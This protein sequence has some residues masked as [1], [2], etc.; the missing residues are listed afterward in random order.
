M[1]K[2]DSVSIINYRDSLSKET[3]WY[4]SGLSGFIKKWAALGWPGVE[5]DAPIV[6]DEMRVEGNRK[7]TAVRTMDPVEGPLTDIE[8]QA[9]IDALKNARLTGEIAVED[10]ALAW[11]AILLS[12]RPIQLASL[13]ICDLKYSTSHDGIPTYVLRVP[14]AKQRGKLARDE[15]FDRALLPEI[16]KLISHHI[17]EVEKRLKGF[18]PDVSSAPLFPAVRDIENWLDGFE[19]HTTADN[20]GGRITFILEGLAVHSERTGEPLNIFPTRLRRTLG[21]HAAIEGHGELLIAALLDHS[22]TQNAG[23]YVEARPEI[24]ERIDKAIAMRMAPL[25]Q[26]F[27]GVLVDGAFG[28]DEEDYLISDPRYGDGEQ[29]V[30]GCGS[31]SFCSLAAPIACYTC[32]HFRP[33]LDGP[34]EEILDGLLGERDRLMNE[35][36]ARI[37]SINDRTI[38]AVAQVVEECKKRR[39]ALPE[40][41]RGVNRRAIL[42]P[43]RRPMLTP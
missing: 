13:K 1:S 10:E 28:A 11:L 33:W 34:H 24:V 21:T 29:A 4:L 35:G 30:G 2:I 40:A 3:K 25:A 27:A 8:R 7:G 38:L 26:A 31:H 23:V 12:P 20:I 17:A 9:L 37:A 14:R 36:S 43:D 6:L 39:S 16:G 42:T 22:D 19:W 32:R 18:V 41:A 5:P 15:F